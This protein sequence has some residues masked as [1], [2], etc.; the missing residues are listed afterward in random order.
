MVAV[1]AVDSV[2]VAAPAEDSAVADMVAPAVQAAVAEGTQ[3][4]V[5]ANNQWLTANSQQPTCSTS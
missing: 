5:D 3:L 4:A 2:A 1:Q